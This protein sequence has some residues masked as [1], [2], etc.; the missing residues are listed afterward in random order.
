MRAISQ[1]FRCFDEV[2][3]RGSIRKAAEGLHLTPAAVHQQVLNFEEQ[4]GVALFDRLPRG[5]QLTAAGEIVLAAVRRSQRDF[6]AALSQ[7]DDLRSLRR[8]HVVVAV[9]H[10][11]ADTLLPQVIEATARSHPGLSYT[12]RTG[13]GEAILRWLAQGDVDVGLCLQRVAPAGVAEVRRWPQRLGLVTPPGHP[14]AAATG[15]ARLR[16]CL[17]Q[18]LALLAP[19]MELR[20]LFDRLAQRERRPVVPLIETTSV[21]MV[22]RLAAAG[23]AIGFLVQENVAQDVADGRLAW[24]PLADADAGARIGLYQRTGQTASV[25]MGVFVELLGKA[26]EDIEAALPSEPRARPAR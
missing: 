19:D 24:R 23:T 13:N 12:V 3:R 9:S 26:L 6:D 7:L 20:S 2:A 8:G 11:S 18:P 21:T 4:V 14:L 5:M 16:D 10:S 17:D 1:A 25:A 22:R 15:S